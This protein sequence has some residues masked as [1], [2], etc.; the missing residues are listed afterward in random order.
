MLFHSIHSSELMY[1]AISKLWVKKCFASSVCIM[2]RIVNYFS[3]TTF[4]LPV[5]LKPI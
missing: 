5:F 3:I 2:L 4:S 1:N